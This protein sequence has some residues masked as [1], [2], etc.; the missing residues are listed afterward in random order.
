VETSVPSVHTA[1]TCPLRPTY[2]LAGL[3]L[4]RA[5]AE[6]LE[7][8]LIQWFAADEAGVEIVTGDTRW[9]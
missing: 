6:Q 3:I 5:I 4:K 8:I 2:F 9:F 7:K 1:T